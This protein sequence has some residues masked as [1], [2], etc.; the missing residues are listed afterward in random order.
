MM[1]DSKYQEIIDQVKVEFPEDFEEILGNCTHI[2]VHEEGLE[3]VVI[4]AIK[5]KVSSFTS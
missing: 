4:H 3:G 2:E 1:T 5:P